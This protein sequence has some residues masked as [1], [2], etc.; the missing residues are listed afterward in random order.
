MRVITS[1]ISFWGVVT[2]LSMFVSC[3]QPDVNQ[4]DEIVYGPVEQTY[5]LPDVS[6]NIYYVSPDGNASAEGLELDQPTV[7]EKAFANVK[8]GDA[9]ILRGGIYRTGNLTFNQGI[10]MQPYRDEKPV[11]NGSLV[12]DS[13][14]QVEDGLWVTNWEKLFPAG[15]EDWWNRER[16]EKQTPMHRFNNDAVF[17]DGQFLQ[18]AGSTDDVNEETFYVDYDDNKIYIGINPEGR[19]VEITAFKKAIYRT[20]HTV[21]G[22]EPDKK[23]PVISGITFTQY[24]DTMVHIGGVGLEIDQHGRDVMGTV[25]EN[26]TFSN[27]FRIGLFAISDS[28]VMR[29]CHV[30][31]TNTE[32]VY[33]VASAG[34][35][36]E[37]NIF[38]NNNIEQWT[39]FFPS[40]VKIFNQSHNAMVRENLIRNQPHS[41]GVWWDVG[42]DD[43]VFINNHVENVSQSGF[44]FEISQGAIVAGNVFENCGQSIFVLNSRDVKVYN[45][46]IINSMVNFRR[47]DR[48]DKPGTF[49]W[50]VTTG[51]GVEERDN[52]VM[53]NNLMYM[54]ESCDTLMLYTH[55]PDFMCE[56]LPNPQ[57]KELNNNVYVRNYKE[58]D[59][60]KALMQWSPYP[61]EDCKTLLFTPDELNEFNGTLATG[62]EYIENIESPLFVDLKNK[63][64][65]LTPEFSNIGNPAPMPAKIVTLLDVEAGSKPFVGA[66]AP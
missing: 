50:H 20:L 34:I 55:Q 40:S 6:G 49:G 63:D 2:L 42:N 60:E 3:S 37:R 56:R 41:N 23:G 51:P 11:L 47:Y 5:Q 12:A 36:L 43:G 24:P 59:G 25:F 13:W 31:N 14:S 33:I 30:A 29:N 35:L 17:I 53:V 66:V 62:S 28:L 21:H 1:V 58:G 45:N 18:S 65:Q 48:G 9:I 52:H 38:E 8:S 27:S 19:T 32:G 39:G 44:F 15:T 26:C 22:K 4:D 61:D 57:F 10:T 54:D 46:T 64:F 16:N 7:I